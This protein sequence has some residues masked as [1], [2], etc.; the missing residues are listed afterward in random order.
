MKGIILAGGSGSRLYPLTIPVNKQLLPVYDKPMIYYPLSTLLL[1][2]IKDIL[3][4]TT[5]NDAHL[6]KL[7]LKDGSQWGIKISY[8]IQEKPNGLAEA[9]IIGE[10][11]IG[12][13]T[14]CLILGDNIFHGHGLSR[15]LTNCAEL[16][17]GAYV[18]GYRVQ[19]PERYGVVEFD[20]NDKVVSIVEKPKKPKS[21]YAVAGLYFYDNRV[22]NFAK[23]IQP[24][25]R[26]ELEITDINNCYLSDG[27]LSVA[28][29][30]RGIAWL[31]TGTH[32]SLLDAAS[33]I[34]TLEKRQ[35][36]QIC[37]PDEIAYVKGYITKEQLRIN[38]KSLEKNS[39]GQYL[40]NLIKDDI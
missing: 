28:K 5:P 34:R 25:A 21:S 15:I 30:S 32:D 29:F 12:N 11:F 10:S 13:D 24:S 18:F 26:G 27:S 7:L 14:V 4:I 3:V 9:F 19:D 6:Y 8:A 35:N 22:I 20:A 17:N 33:Y 16:K 31:D 37:S 38:A 1:S 40:L 39:Y 36:C 23:G 2:G